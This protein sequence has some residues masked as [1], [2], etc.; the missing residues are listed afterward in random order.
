MEFVQIGNPG[1]AADTTGFGSVGYVFNIGKYEISRD[2][3][4]KVNASAVL[5]LTLYDMMSFGG[6]GANRPATGLSWNEAARFVNWLNTS[7]GYQAAYKFTGNGPN[8]NITLWETG[9]Y[10][11]NNQYR[12]KDSFYFLPSADEWYK[13]AY[14]SLNGS[15]FK[16]STGSDSIPTPVNEGT[17]PNTAVY[18]GQVGPADINNAGGLS[19][20]GTMAQGGNVW[21]LNESAFDGSNDEEGEN[22]E[23]RGVSW[24]STGDSYKLESLYR[25]PAAPTYEGFGYDGFR[26]AMVP[27]PSVLSLL[28]IGLGGWAMMQ[29][30]RS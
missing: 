10:N 23:Y 12:H 11:G 16:Y 15:W 1:N 19:A 14:G 5:E 18:G 25:N 6:N 7:K 29:R 4:E 22:R 27:E 3:V 2:M 17:T 13:S 8:D 20:F 24:G 28:A 30:R 9:Q 26:V 21:E